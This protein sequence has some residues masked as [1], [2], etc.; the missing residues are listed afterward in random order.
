MIM[1]NRILLLEQGRNKVETHK[2]NLKPINSLF[3]S[4]FILEILKK[5]VLSNSWLYRRC[6]GTCNNVCLGICSELKSNQRWKYFDIKD[7]NI[8]LIASIIIDL[9]TIQRL[10]FPLP[11]ITLHFH[12]LS[13]S[14]L[15]SLALNSCQALDINLRQRQPSSRSRLCLRFT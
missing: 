15:Q 2:Y 6:L 5:M 11:L 9:Q 12:Y 7:G 4:I 3:Y 1:E 10:L 13:L 8:R 14:I